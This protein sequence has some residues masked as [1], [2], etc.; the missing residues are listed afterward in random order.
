M[1]DSPESK[2]VRLREEFGGLVDD[3]TLKRLVME[4][5]GMKMAAEKKIADFSD[6][7]EITAVVK[8][9]RIND[10][11]TFNKRTGGQG[12]VRNINV[13]DESGNCR[14]TLWDDDV[15]LPEGLNIQVGTSLKLTDCYTKQTEYGVDVSKGKKGK[16]EM[17]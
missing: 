13:E 11:K 12:R 3:E 14:L 1:S 9:A 5:G 6:R 16:I 7:E 8:V 10:T 2:I 15:D 4:E 17:L